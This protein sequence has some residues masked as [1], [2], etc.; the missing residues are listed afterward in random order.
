MAF[1]MIYV[2]YGSVDEADKITSHLLE[3]KLVSCANLFP[4][5]S[6]YWWKG[7]IEDS[8][9]VVSILKTRS[10]NLEKVKEAIKKMHSYDVPCIVKMNV[11]ANEEF[12]EWVERESSD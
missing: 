12:E 2:T 11:G 5:T 9:E 7:K 8:D 1:I 6:S 10:E 3:K 4:I